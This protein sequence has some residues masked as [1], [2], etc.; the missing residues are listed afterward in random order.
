MLGAPTNDSLTYS[1]V[2]Q[3]SLDFVRYSLLPHL[4]KI[5]LAISHDADLTFDRQ[6]VRF[7]LD[8]LL[9][10]DSAGRA[11][12]YEKALDPVQGWMT[13]DEV[14]RLE[15]LAPEAEPPT[16]EQTVEQ[17]LATTNGGGR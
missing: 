7:E 8:G 6:F 13:R 14:R 17:L 4:R 16:R 11:S 10:P 3:Q 12:F 15:D 9:R 2:E 1:T 5:E